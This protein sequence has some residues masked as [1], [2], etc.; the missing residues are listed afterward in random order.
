MCDDTKDC[1]VQLCPP[2]D[3]HMC[4][5]HVEIWNELIIKFGATS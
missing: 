2:E 5:K 4:S 1:I 3:E